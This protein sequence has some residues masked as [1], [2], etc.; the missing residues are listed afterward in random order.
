MSQMMVMFD[1]KFGQPY[2]YNISTK[3][4]GCQN[5]TPG[6]N[7]KFQAPTKQLSKIDMYDKL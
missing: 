6:W 2:T 4:S 1:Y 3:R 7:C 5:L